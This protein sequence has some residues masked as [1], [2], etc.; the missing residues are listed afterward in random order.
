MRTI[1]WAR[2]IDV[3]EQHKVAGAGAGSFAQAQLKYRNEAAQGKH[4]HGYVHQTL[5]DLG[6]LG[7]AISLV[8]LVAWFLA[9]GRTLGLR[10]P[11]AR[12]GL[13]ARTSGAHGPRARGGRVRDSL[14]PRLDLVRP[15]GR[16]DG[17]FLR[18]DGSRAAGRSPP[19][20][21]RSPR[22]GPGCCRLRMFARL[23]RTG[24]HAAAARS[25]PA[26]A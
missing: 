10:P 16:R 13:V 5:A 15:G 22:P 12:G 21:R 8:A 17:P 2:A 18:R 20:R 3:W 24:A 23:C 19:P 14:R 1:Y 7:L 26:S 9:A 6:L 11:G 4:A 25:S